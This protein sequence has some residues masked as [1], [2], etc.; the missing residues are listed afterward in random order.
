LF[1][2]SE[3]HE[4]ELEN[5]DLFDDRNDGSEVFL[6]SYFHLRKDMTCGKKFE[7]TQVAPVM[8]SKGY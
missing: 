3:D 2:N 8:Q 7:V 6:V 4:D 5:K 1:T